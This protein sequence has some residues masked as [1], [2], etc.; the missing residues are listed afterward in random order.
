MGELA[1]TCPEPA[2]ASC[3]VL[4]TVEVENEC[5]MRVCNCPRD[6]VWSFG[7]FWQVLM[8]TL[9]GS[10]ACKSADKDGLK[11]HQYGAAGSGA[12]ATSEIDNL[13][14]KYRRCGC[15]STTGDKP[16]CR[17]FKP[18][19]GCEAFVQTLAQGG[20]ATP[21]LATELLEAIN[22]I[23]C[24]VQHT[25]DPTRTDA[26][27]LR[28][29][30]GREFSEVNRIVKANTRVVERP[31]PTRCVPWGL[32]DALDMV[33]HVTAD[34]RLLALTQNGVVVDVVKQGVQDRLSSTE[35]TVESV[36]QELATVKG[37]LEK[38]KKML[39][40]YRPP[41][42]GGG[43]ASASSTEGQGKSGATRSRSKRGGAQ[44]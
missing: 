20:R 33:G 16:C 5:L 14:R 7:S 24:S 22:W 18:E 31:L 42:S 1:F 41:P 40:Q 8:A 28:A 30:R 19:D 25:F 27:L 43:P 13:A 36:Q 3:V 39:S 21:D 17:E 38:V 23:R 9:F 29:L 12:D 4:G 10:L 37:E 32:I 35:T 2:H 15:G 11:D 6:Y 44:P 34:N 26:L